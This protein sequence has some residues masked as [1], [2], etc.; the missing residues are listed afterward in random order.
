M[1]IKQ[2]RKSA[3]RRLQIALQGVDIATR[4]ALAE[5][6]P[7]K[8]E[9]LRRR[10]ADYTSEAFGG[11]GIKCIL[12]EDPYGPVVPVHEAGLAVLALRGLRPAD[13]DRAFRPAADRIER[14]IWEIAQQQDSEARCGS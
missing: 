13:A 6:P 14:A 12:T 10:V 5:C 4:D 7:E 3:E 2:P 9:A 8:H 11:L 1:K